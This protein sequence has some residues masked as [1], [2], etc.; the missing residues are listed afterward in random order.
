MFIQRKT[1]LFSILNDDV[2]G[3]IKSYIPT[4]KLVWLT[5]NDYIKHHTVI[6]RLILPNQYDDY[7]RDIVKHDCAFV[8]ER[9]LCEQFDKFH[10]WKHFDYNYVRYNSYLSYLREYAN[11][12]GSIKCVKI[13]DEIAHEKGFSKKWYKYRGIIIRSNSVGL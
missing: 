5:K 4:E 10:A 11:K 3:V 12:N 7:L 2:L 1:D 6:K 9:I 8:F 13:I